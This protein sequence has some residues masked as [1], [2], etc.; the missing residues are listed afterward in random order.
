[1][2]QKWHEVAMPTCIINTGL[3]IT[4]HNASWSWPEV[5]WQPGCLSLARWDGWFGVQ[6]GCHTLGGNKFKDFSKPFQGL[7]S[8]CSI[9]I[10][11]AFYQVM[12]LAII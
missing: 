4:G 11:A 10:P 12:F 5:D 9:T 1:M 7:S 3:C 8:E 2:M 6:V